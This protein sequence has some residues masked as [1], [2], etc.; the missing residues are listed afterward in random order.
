MDTLPLRERVLIIPSLSPQREFLTSLFV[1]AVISKVEVW[2]PRV[3]LVFPWVWEE[4]IYF[5][6]LFLKFYFGIIS[7]MFH[8]ILVGYI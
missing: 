4:N 6:V 5:Y 2:P 8:K 7:V 1:E 3:Y